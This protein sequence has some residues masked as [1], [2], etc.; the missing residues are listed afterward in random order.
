MHEVYVLVTKRSPHYFFNISTSADAHPAVPDPAELFSELIAAHANLDT[1]ARTFVTATT[2]DT[3]KADH[4]HFYSVLLEA[5]HQGPQHMWDVVE[6]HSRALVPVFLSFVDEE[7]RVA[8]VGA[9]HT[10][11]LAVWRYWLMELWGHFL[12]G[13]ESRLGLLLSFSSSW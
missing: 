12:F 5:V 1:L 9:K 6:R 3:L 2:P 13:E 4:A 7:Y 8:Y 11:D 10:Q